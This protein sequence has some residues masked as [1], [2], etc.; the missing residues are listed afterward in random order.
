MNVKLLLAALTVLL[1][2][3]PARAAGDPPDAVILK[4]ELNFRLNDDGSVT[5]REYRLVRINNRRA[6]SAFADPRIPYREGRDTVKILKAVTH[7]R[8]GTVLPVPAYSLN[9]ASPRDI[10]GW[11]RYADW[12][13]RIVSFSGI[14]PGV[15]L[16]LEFEV[17]EAA[18]SPPRLS[19]DLRIS[20]D[21][22]I[23]EKVV[24]LS[25]PDKIEPRHRV[26][27]VHLLPEVSQGAGYR[28]WRWA[29]TDL[30]A[31]RGESTS[32]PWEMRC[33]R[34][35]FSTHAGTEAWVREYLL[36]VNDAATPDPAIK[37][38]AR[39]TV[40]REEDLIERCRLLSGRLA[41]TF[42]VIP[43]L[44]AE[45][46]PVCVSAPVAFRSN[47]GNRLES[48]A[49]L[50]ACL[51]ALD[52]EVE[53]AVAV[54]ARTWDHMPVDSGLQALLIRV[55]SDDE[56]RF[57]D[58]VGGLL[59]PGKMSLAIYSVDGPSH[60]MRLSYLHPLGSDAISE[61]KIT[62]RLTLER[63]GLLRGV[64]TME[65]S[66]AFFDPT[67]F[68]G[69]KSQKKFV[70]TVLALLA[71]GLTADSVDVLA[72]SDRRF[73]VRT[74]VATA[75]PVAAVA[76]VRTLRLGADP[77]FM[78][79]FPLPLSESQRTTAV[80]LRGPFREILD[81]EF[82]YPERVSVL[83][84]PAEVNQRL[85]NDGAVLQTVNKKPGGLRL[86][87]SI[88]VNRTIV[89]PEE[90]RVLRTAINLLRTEGG[91]TILLNK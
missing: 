90:F 5:R 59:T 86:R 78:A 13:E 53:L 67:E 43:S 47:Y 29:F 73:E 54:N 76:G 36:L 7:L 42:H 58:P 25:L 19:R 51:R 35:R 55:N 33:P 21:Y 64:L 45:T 62:G 81:L 23:M 84:A 12:R 31:T 83:A 72:L 88:F 48:A 39:A 27:G 40:G 38:F 50:A 52:C 70:G 15:V 9:T 75:K 32:L 34:L 77:L 85:G 2:A 4:E 66:G 17:R 10:A 71:P 46:P 8:S 74:R 63:S 44:K 14:E 82:R 41:K 56:V 61:L 79:R 68:Q 30:P 18:A 3:A 91:R 1:L 49:V 16:E 37:R 57:V 89:C 26:D 22:P 80:D 24:T 28:T 11:P 65:C 20:A 6:I 60:T 69:A 87:R